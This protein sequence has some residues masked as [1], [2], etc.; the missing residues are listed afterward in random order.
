LFYFTFSSWYHQE[1]YIQASLGTAYLVEP[2]E[3]IPNQYAIIEAREKTNRSAGSGAASCKA[4]QKAQGNLITFARR[5]VWLGGL[6]ECPP[7]QDAVSDRPRNDKEPFPQLILFIPSSYMWGFGKYQY[8]LRAALPANR[9]LIL[10]R[11]TQFLSDFM[12]SW[13]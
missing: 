4:F 8:T 7:S 10:G 12:S 1:E 6:D 5:S 11:Q 2:E 13:R 9:G 3:W